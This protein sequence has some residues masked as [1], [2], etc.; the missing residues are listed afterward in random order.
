MLPGTSRSIA[1][2]LPLGT[3]LWLIKCNATWDISQHSECSTTRYTPLTLIYSAMLSGT[4]RS[5]ASALSLGTPLWLIKCNAT[6]DIS[7][8]SECSTTRYTPLTYIVQCYRET[9]IS[10]NLLLGK[11]NKCTK[12]KHTH[13]YNP[14]KHKWYKFYEVPGVIILH[15]KHH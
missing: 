13:S 8:N 7:P 12:L 3:H 6:W 5:I 9:I 1:S 4:S 10:I 2:A 15:I 14:K 11:P